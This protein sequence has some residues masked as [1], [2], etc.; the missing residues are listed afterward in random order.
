MIPKKIFHSQKIQFFYYIIH[1]DP[2]DQKT[3]KKIAKKFDWDIKWI[4]KN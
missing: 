2:K 4:N 1:D 3:Q